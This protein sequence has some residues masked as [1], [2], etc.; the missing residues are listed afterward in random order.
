MSRLKYYA[1]NYCYPYFN[2][3]WRLFTPCPD[4]NFEVI[5]SYVV[6]GK[7]RYALP[8]SVVLSEKNILN[9]KEALN[10]SMTAS[11]GYVAF[12]KIRVNGN[13]Y[14]YNKTVS[15]EIY[16]N[17]FKKYLSH[18]EGSEISELALILKLKSIRTNEEVY[19]VE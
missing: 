10:F 4:N 7:R 9:G 14:R 11:C 17:A 19:V 16:K 8:L 6:N 15:Y 12:E 18:K 5:A 3:D 13:I 2:Q 1:F